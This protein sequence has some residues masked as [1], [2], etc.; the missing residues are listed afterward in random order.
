MTLFICLRAYFYEK[1]TKDDARIAAG[2]RRDITVL[3]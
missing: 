2:D 1:K 3:W